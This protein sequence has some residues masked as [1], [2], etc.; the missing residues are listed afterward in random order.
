VISSDPQI[1]EDNQRIWDEAINTMSI[2]TQPTD[3]DNLPP[4][5]RHEARGNA[6]FIHQKQEGE[7]TIGDLKQIIQQYRA[8]SDVNF[9]GLNVSSAHNS[10]TA[11]EAA[12]FRDVKTGPG[13]LSGVYDYDT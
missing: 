13:L 8:D 6:V 12:G 7:V 10:V 5:Y 2:L 9:I 11:L 1:P 3:S 4:N